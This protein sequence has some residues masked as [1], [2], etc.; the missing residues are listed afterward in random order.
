MSG[1]SPP[2]PRDAR[3]EAITVAAIFAFG[4]GLVSLVLVGLTS[5]LIGPGFDWSIVSG[6]VTVCA[7]AVAIGLPVLI[8]DRLKHREKN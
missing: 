3:W 8:I 1:D 6:F 7:I 5:L 4:G 2:P